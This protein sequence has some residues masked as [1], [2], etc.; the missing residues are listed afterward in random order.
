M[1]ARELAG[2][3]YFL[4]SRGPRLAI[5]IIES[6]LY[7]GILWFSIVLYM[8]SFFPKCYPFSEMLV[9]ILFY[10]LVMPWG[11]SM[12]DMYVFEIYHLMVFI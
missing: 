7:L 5:I 11:C 6:Q 10:Y 1:L 4:L 3:Q 2:I 12:I 8:K 9:N